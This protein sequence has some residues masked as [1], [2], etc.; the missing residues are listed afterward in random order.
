MQTGK[1]IS[2]DVRTGEVTERT[3]T[4]PDAP[5]VDEAENKI[6]LIKLKNLLLAKGIIVNKKEVE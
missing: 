3:I 4:I 5:V 2:V 1:Q 6:D